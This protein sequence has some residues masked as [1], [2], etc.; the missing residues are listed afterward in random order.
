M[1]EQQPRREYEDET[2]VVGDG[3]NGLRSTSGQHDVRF[4]WLAI[5]AHRLKRQPLHFDCK[6]PV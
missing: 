5:S 3:V 4:Y 1:A 2:A 6:I